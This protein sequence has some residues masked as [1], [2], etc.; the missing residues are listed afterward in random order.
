TGRIVTMCDRLVKGG[1]KVAR[2][3]ADKN[4]KALKF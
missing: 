4:N 3:F 2:L 1:N